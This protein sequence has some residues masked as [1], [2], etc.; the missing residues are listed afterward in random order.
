LECP[1]A[2]LSGCKFEKTLERGR[3]HAGA[4]YIKNK[5]CSIGVRQKLCG[6]IVESNLLKSIDLTREGRQAGQPW[7]IGARPAAYRT[8]ETR[9][10]P[11]PPLVR[12]FNR[13]LA[14]NNRSFQR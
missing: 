4:S 9:S 14:S 1:G 12:L 2:T 11:R 8:S 10:T 3:F 6:K 7:I 5:F 13:H